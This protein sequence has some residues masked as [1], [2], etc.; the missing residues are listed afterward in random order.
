MIFTFSVMAFLYSASFANFL[1]CTYIN[2]V[3]I[4]K[5]FKNRENS[6]YYSGIHCV[7]SLTWP[8]I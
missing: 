6:D 3:N 8:Y 7:Y 2:F 5:Q 4:I 1:H